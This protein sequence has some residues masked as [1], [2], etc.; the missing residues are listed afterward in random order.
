MTVKL[1]DTKTFRPAA[2][3]RP[4]AGLGGRLGIVT[5]T[6]TFINKKHGWYRVE[7]ETKYFGRQHECFP[8][9]G[10]EYKDAED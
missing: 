10:E 7:Y 6:V 8:L 9:N 4:T 3:E 5:G 2:Y 1:G